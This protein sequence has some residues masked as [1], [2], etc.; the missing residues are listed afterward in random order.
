M[1]WVG[2]ALYRYNVYV[3]SFFLTGNVSWSPGQ[4]FPQ[5]PWEFLKSNTAENITV[6][7]FGK[8]IYSYFVMEYFNI[9]CR[10]C[11]FFVPLSY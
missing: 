3:P 9:H 11:E 6:F 2:K 5:P 1:V 8:G 7:L 10:C 4:I